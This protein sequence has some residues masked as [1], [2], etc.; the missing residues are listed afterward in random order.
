MKKQKQHINLEEERYGL[1]MSDESFDLDIEYG[2][3]FLRTDNVHL[4]T[5][6]RLDII[7][8]KSHDLYGQSKPSDRKY[9]EP[10]KLYVSISTKDSNQIDYADSGIIRDD[11]GGIEFGIYIKELEEN[12]TDIN[13]GDIVSYNMSGSK[14]RYFEVENANNIVDETSKTFGGYK[15]YWRKVTAVPVKDD[16]VVFLNERK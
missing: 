14:N 4:I 5:L 8:S 7:E 2:R 1:Y 10:I 3:Q 9:L 6:Y 12:N 13:R 16:V 15:P 11:V